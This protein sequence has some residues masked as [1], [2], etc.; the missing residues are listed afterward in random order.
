MMFLAASQRTNSFYLSG[1]I[2]LEYYFAKLTEYLKT[3]Q[4]EAIKQRHLL[5][6]N[7][8]WSQVVSQ[9]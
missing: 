1:S 3:T 8:E 7:T 4:F 5:A 2:G 9:S 6:G